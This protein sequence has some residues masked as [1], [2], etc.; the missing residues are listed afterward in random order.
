[1]ANNSKRIKIDFTCSDEKEY[2]RYMSKGCIANGWKQVNNDCWI[3]SALFSL[4][5]SDVWVIFSEILDGMN[6]SKNANIKH[7]S[8]SISNYLRYINEIG[9][10]HV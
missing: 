5:A 6:A 4:F 7:I 1:M 9:R 3:D 8:K 2:T 10:A